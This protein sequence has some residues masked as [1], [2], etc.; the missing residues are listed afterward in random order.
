VGNLPLALFRGD[1]IKRVIAI[2]LVT[3]FFLTSCDNNE[4][5]YK[6]YDAQFLE[7]FD[8]A[9]T[10][11]GYTKTKE[12]FEKISQT[13]YDELKTYHQLFDIYNDYDGINNLKT[14]NDNAGKSPV[15]V[16]KKIIEMLKFATELTEKTNG[17][18]NVAFGSVLQIWHQYREHGTDFPED[19]KLPNKQELE[20]ANLHT[21]ISK[22][23]IDEENS[24][25]FLQDSLMSLDV[26]GIAKGYAVEK[27]AQLLEKEGTESILLNIGG[28]VRAI[29]NRANDNTPWRIGLDNPL[30]KTQ[31][32]KTL[33]ISNTSMVTSGDYQR[34]YTVDGKNYHH[35]IDKDTLFPSEYYRAVTLV[36]RDSGMADG[37]T[38]YLYNIPFEQGKAFVENLEGAEALWIFDDGSI[39]YTEG[40]KK[41]II[42][43]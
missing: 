5:E 6:R 25:V 12:E 43:S 30:D 23:I 33:S 19:A 40:M 18:F 29:G 8:T 1:N 7:V 3:V 39:E 26:G 38:T 41:I 21:D 13:V 36:Y 27:T 17:E 24:T 16:D 11:I 35:I 20:E 32:I 31:I 22:I 15:K 34:Y 10:I 4:S 9:S 37:L 14:I 42:D 2:L 28:N